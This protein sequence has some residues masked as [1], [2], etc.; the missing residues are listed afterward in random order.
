[1]ADGGYDSAYHVQFAADAESRMIG[2]PHQSR[3]RFEQ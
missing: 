1:M 2:C 3:I